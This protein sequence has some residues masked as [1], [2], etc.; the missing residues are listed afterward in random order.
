MNIITVKLKQYVTT[1]FLLSVYN[2]FVYPFLV[3]ACILWGNNNYEAPLP[4]L[5][6]LQNKAVRIIHNVP[7]C[8]P[9]TPHYVILGLIKLSDIIKLNRCDIL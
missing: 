5:V 4:S 6:R 2:S 7:L 1:N 9:I 8:E 3:H